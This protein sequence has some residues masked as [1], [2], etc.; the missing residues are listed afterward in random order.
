MMPRVLRSLQRRSVRIEI[1]DGDALETPLAFLDRVEHA[2]VVAS[3]T[4]VR[5]HQQRMFHVVAIHDVTKLR[6]R[7]DFLCGRLVGNIFAIGKVGRIDHMNMA[8]DL[9]FIENRHV[10]R[11]DG[12]NTQ[13]FSLRFLA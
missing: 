3:I 6:G 2:G 4:G 12:P 7:A 10:C 1:D 11:S 5:L 9:R 8:V 13:Q